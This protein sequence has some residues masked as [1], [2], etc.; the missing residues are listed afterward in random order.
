MADGAV[1]RLNKDPVSLLPEYTAQQERLFAGLG[2]MPNST[3]SGLSVRE[4]KRLGSGLECAISGDGLGVVV[5]PGLAVVTHAVAAGGDYTVVIPTAV[6]KTLGSKP[7]AGQ[8]RRDTVVIDVQDEDVTEKTTTLREANIELLA[9]TPTAGTPTATAAGTMQFEIAQVHFDGSNTPVI[10]ATN[11]R[12]VW[13]AGGIGVV[14]SQTERD[15]LAAYNGLVVYRDDT[16]DFEARVN[17]AWR[18]LV[19]ADSD[20][21]DYAILGGTGFTENG[22]RVRVVGNRVTFEISVNRSGGTITGNTQPDLHLF[23]LEPE[24]RPADNPEE[25]GNLLSF[26]AHN[27]TAGGI[28][29]I[30]IGTSDG[31]VRLA[32]TNRDIASGNRLRGT[33]DFYT[34]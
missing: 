1:L 4:G 14:F 22:T 34:D 17:G 5:Q 8:K 32:Y 13:A 15:N 26:G 30:N 18:S 21:V 3:A 12:Y 31:E 25:A 29:S 16:D 24:H 9:G 23:T 19:G 10:Q 7:T 2:M 28:A 20:W 11:P 33:V 27:G 6:T